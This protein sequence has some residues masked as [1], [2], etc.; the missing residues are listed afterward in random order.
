MHVVS[1]IVRIGPEAAGELLPQN[2][3]FKRK[4]GVAVRRTMRGS[5]VGRLLLTSGKHPG[6]VGDTSLVQLKGPTVSEKIPFLAQGPVD[7]P[8]DLTPTSGRPT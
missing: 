2:N 3:D 7:R 1:K 8:K 6:G 4:V 5:R